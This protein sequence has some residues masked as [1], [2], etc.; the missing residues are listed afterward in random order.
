MYFNE[1]EGRWVNVEEFLIFVGDFVWDLKEFSDEEFFLEFEGFEQVK[2]DEVLLCFLVNVFL[3]FD[4]QIGD[5][6]EN[7]LFVI[8]FIIYVVKGFEWFVVFVFV[9]YNGLILYMRF[10]DNDEE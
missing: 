2:E 5:D 6:G 8:I 4:V 3:V 9:V 7:K 1:Y 10:D